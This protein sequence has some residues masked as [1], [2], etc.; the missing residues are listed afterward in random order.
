VKN[1]QCSPITDPTVFSTFQRTLAISP[2]FIAGRD[3]GQ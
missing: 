2:Q 1:N 3:N